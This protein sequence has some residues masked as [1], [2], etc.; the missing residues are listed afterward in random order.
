MN[1]SPSTPQQTRA[2]SARR[3]HLNLQDAP[4]SPALV[5]L[6]KPDVDGIVDRTDGTLHKDCLKADLILKIPAWP[7]LQTEPDDYSTVQLQFTLTGAEDNY[8]AIGPTHR[9]DGPLEASDFPLL[10]PFPQASL[11]RNG[12]LWVRY[13]L[14]DHR[15]ELYDS[16][17]LELICDSVAPWGDEPA[18]PLNTPPGVI[19]DAY[20]TGN[21]GIELDIPDYVDRAAGDTYQVFYLKNWSE[22]DTDYE[23]PSAVGPV[24]DNLKI[25]IPDT[26][27]RPLGD[28]RFY[29]VYYLF[30]KAQ[31]RSRI[32]LPAT[33]DVVLTPEPAALL[34]PSVPQAETDG[35]VNLA[36]AQVGV[37][38]HIL[39]YANHRPEDTIVVTWGSTPL[40]QEQVGS[41]GFPI[42]ILVPSDILQDEYGTATGRK[43]T[44]ISYQVLRG[45][46]P[47]GPAQRDVD[48][49]FSVVG[50]VRPNPDT[51]WPDPVNAKI[52]APVITSHTGVVD[53]ITTPDRGENA[54]LTFDVFEGA[55]D[56]QVVDFYWN[57][58]LL[59]YARWV[60]DQAPGTPKTVTVLWQTI[61]DGGDNL[62]LPVYYTVRAS[63]D[64]NDNAQQSITKHIKV[65]VVDKT[66]DDLE[67][68]GINSRGWLSCAS[69][70]DPDDPTA[71]PAIRIQVPPCH[72]LN[73]QPGATMT[74][75]WEVYDQE[76]GGNLITTVTKTESVL[77]DAEQINNGFVW[78]VQ[79][80]EDHIRPIY[81]VAPSRGR[82]E[83]SYVIDTPSLISNT[84][85][86]KISIADQGTGSSCDLNR[87]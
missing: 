69:I 45:Q 3:K 61:Q 6:T 25:K 19:N 73:V 24:P 86:N 72:R 87:P 57:S 64:P 75:T 53:Q 17:P 38:V 70:W 48:V 85:A 55:V 47:Y 67:F 84:T 78:R 30:D 82:A 40:M 49:D 43:S 21:N 15:G 39:E 29:I 42:R 65:E 35:V 62:A 20:L 56:G 59:P 28:G 77:L 34:P 66:P 27:V 37:H 14:E 4:L 1:T 52:F 32:R 2:I 23:N 18:P 16:T 22:D 31:N 76:V 79:P 44:S 68:L 50:P 81:D 60:V 36:D 9:Y 33:V 41:R 12:K 63:E 10:L 83:V 71:L 8:T 11:P 26:V 5:D 13:E 46:A 80:Y 54:S 58:T 51:D 74:L 7:E